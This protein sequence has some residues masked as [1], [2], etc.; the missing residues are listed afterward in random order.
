MPQKHMETSE[1]KHTHT[2][3]HTHTQ[4]H[5]HTVTVTV[6]DLL[7]VHRWRSM[8]PDEVAT[9]SL[10]VCLD[11]AITSPLEDG[12]WILRVCHHTYMYIYT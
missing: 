5:T 10:S 3:T 4:T 7:S 9:L 11:L 2:H 1:G 12:E 8:E 6:G